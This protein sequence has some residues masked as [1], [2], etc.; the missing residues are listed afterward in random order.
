MKISFNPPLKGN[1]LP[2][3]E[4]KDAVFSKKILGDGFGIYP[5]NKSIL[6]PVLGTVHSIF[7]TKHMMILRHALCH[8][9]IHLGLDARKNIVD[10]N[11]KVGDKVSKGQTI[12]NLKSSFFDQILSSQ[13]VN[14]VFLETKSCY[15]NNHY[16]ICD[17]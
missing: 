6:S 16:V 2:I 5:Q 3:I 1:M 7:P 14:I 15:F 11:V 13:I 12:G 10:W 17:E 9:M 8:I 4:T